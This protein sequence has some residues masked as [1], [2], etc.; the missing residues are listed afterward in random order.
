MPEFEGSS[1]GQAPPEQ[2]LWKR[3]GC[4]LGCEGFSAKRSASSTQHPRSPSPGG[5]PR[6]TLKAAYVEIVTLHQR[7]PPALSGA[8]VCPQESQCECKCVRKAGKGEPVATGRSWSG[9]AALRTVETPNAMPA[10]AASVPAASKWP[11]G[12]GPAEPQH[13][14]S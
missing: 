7:L 10:K 2:A 4:R 6:A 1:P 12:S 9:Q 5:W 13:P 8:R 14:A 3:L 11:V